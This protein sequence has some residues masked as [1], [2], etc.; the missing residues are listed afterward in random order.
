RGTARIHTILT[1]MFQ[2]V[3]PSRKSYSQRHSSVLSKE[4]AQKLLGSEVTKKIQEIAQDK[5][6]E[7]YSKAVG[8]PIKIYLEGQEDESETEAQI[9]GLTKEICQSVR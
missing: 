4:A 7:L 2:T 3:E 9:R 5:I 6:R 8:K 1:S